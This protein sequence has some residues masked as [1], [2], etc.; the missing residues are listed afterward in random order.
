[1]SLIWIAD[2]SW[3]LPRDR[4]RGHHGDV[5][6][7]IFIVCAWTPMLLFQFFQAI[8]GGAVLDTHRLTLRR[9]F[10]RIEIP[11]CEIVSARVKYIPEKIDNANAIELEI[12]RS[13]AGIFPHSQEAITLE[14][15]EWFL[16]ELHARAP[17]ITV[18][19]NHR[20]GMLFAKPIQ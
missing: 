8:Y 16:D 11:Y 13:G 2:K 14:K 1:M 7:D 15:P 10:R 12:A 19:P 17:H 6:L 18:L 20:E 3:A 4:A 9:A 5:V